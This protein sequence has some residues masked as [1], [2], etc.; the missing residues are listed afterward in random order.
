[1]PAEDSA[2]ANPRKDQQTKRGSV[3]TIRG[4]NT[5]I[6]RIKI[7]EPSVIGQSSE[8]CSR[9]ALASS[10]SQ[11]QA[12]GSRPALASSSSQAQASGSRP[13]PAL[14]SF[15]SQAQASGNSLG[16][17]I[18]ADRGKFDERRMQKSDSSRASGKKNISLY[19]PLGSTSRRDCPEIQITKTMKRKEVT[20][21]PNVD[22]KGIYI[23]SSTNLSF[24][25]QSDGCLNFG[26]NF[27]KSL[28]FT[29]V[30]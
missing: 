30:D 25:I 23:L 4:Y 17:Q 18:L 27:Q 12:R 24:V 5:E 11:A 15:S 10:S 19:K 21:E 9:T 7:Q 28:F 16:R 1:M 20:E 8:R 29:Y 22:N 6:K 3:P 2:L 13:R 14:A 26:L